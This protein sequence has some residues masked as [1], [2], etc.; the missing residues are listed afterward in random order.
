LDYITGSNG[1]L[2]VDFVGRFEN[3]G[4]DLLKVYDKLGIELRSIPHENRS[5]RGHYSSF[6]TPETKMIVEE[7]F[8]RDIEYF[9]Y[10]FE[11]VERRT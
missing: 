9:G 4:S 10:E 7:R 11:G 8:K 1:N 5:V 6:Y 3:L 2:L